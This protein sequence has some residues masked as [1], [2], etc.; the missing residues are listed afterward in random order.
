MAV[1]HNFREIAVTSCIAYEIEDN[2]ALNEGE[3]EY[4]PLK[5][6]PL[7]T[8]TG[9]PASLAENY[10]NILAPH[11]REDRTLN[12]AGIAT[13]TSTASQKSN[14][15]YEHYYE[16]TTATLSDANTPPIAAAV[17]ATASPTDPMLEAS[18]SASHTKRYENIGATATHES[19][20]MNSGSAA[21]TRT[22][23][24]QWSTGGDERHYDYEPTTVTLSDGTQL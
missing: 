21:S 2:L 1:P 17:P 16:P 18:D 10:E 15:D 9:D 12:D 5:P 23:S 3:Y 14:N 24:P 7:P 11:S 22:V 4:I 13:S 6:P 19:H 20:A 8:R